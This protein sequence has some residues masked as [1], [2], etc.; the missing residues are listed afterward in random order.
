MTRD[1]S[2]TQNRE[3]SW[4][5]FNKRVL[6]EACD[7]TVPL[8]ER[9]K[10]ISIFTS[11]LDEFYM[12]RCGTLHDLSLIDS[13]YR[14]NKSGLTASQQLDR[15]FKR[16]K[17]L[18][19]FKD[20]VYMDVS[21]QL[22]FFDIRE[23]SFEGMN[24]S[25]RDFIDEYYDNFVFPIL[26]PQIIDF[27]HPFPHFR[28][29]ALYIVLKLKGDDDE[30]EFGFI[31]VPESLDS[32]VFLPGEGFNFILMENIILHYADQIFT[33]YSVKFKTVMS[34]TRNADISFLHE[35]IDSDDDYRELV[36]K[37]LK[38]RSRL[39]PIRLQFY[40]NKNKKLVDFLTEK[41]NIRKNQ[42]QVSNSP[43][44]M[45]FVFP[46]IDHIKSKNV[47]LYQKLSYR[48]F[49]TNYPPNLLKNRSMIEQVLERDYLFFYPY[50][51]MDLFLKLL[52]E[53]ANDDR[54]VS[55]KITIYRLAKVSK[56][57]QYLLDALDNGIEVTALIELRARF[58][59]QNNLN[60][61]EVLEEAGCN[62]IYGSEEYKVHSKICLIT[63]RAKNG[64]EYITQLG[65]GNYNE[66]TSKLYTD[67]SY[68]TSRNDIGEDAVLF[69]QN[70]S[71]DN[72]DGDYKKLIVSPTSFK[73]NIADKICEQV[74]LARSGKPALIIMKM[75]S[76]TDRDLIDMLQR[77][78][79]VGVTIKLIIR[80]ICCII[81]GI[82]NVTD[83]IRIISI[84]GR[85]LEHS[86]IYCFGVGDSCEIYL[87]SADLMTRNTEKRVEIGFPIEDRHI[88]HRILDMI[89]IMLSDNVKAREIDIN[90]DMVRIPVIDER[91]DSQEFFI[92]NLFYDELP[93]EEMNSHESIISRLKHIF[94]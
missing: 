9:L 81:P 5:K 40:R 92:N 39:A 79:I 44:N 10:F 59:E 88:R 52:K 2:Y 54:V 84:V 80:G 85:F 73:S 62:V 6:Q 87:S 71:L 72:L 42:I 38:K 82:P 65:T 70:M 14:D 34:V 36:K 63:R 21:K 83:N 20:R 78:S 45:E 57:V 4:L 15:I 50:E 7:D 13:D 37:I 91:V 29:N 68:I 77:A 49:V 56:I 61:A 93:M 18:C 48:P 32:L 89:N 3:L 53:A 43:L 94:D 90:G 31:P 25:Q 51:S 67:L 23:V 27:N 30:T 26:S 58:D 28:N 24:Q 17:E 19:R 86:R 8:L 66:K 1:Y 11:N 41:L 74:A 46:L 22:E 16:T 64:F 47:N 12:V 33:N 35:Q 75:N 69:F 55:I 60:Y 76:L